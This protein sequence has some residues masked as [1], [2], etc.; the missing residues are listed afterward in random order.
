[1]SPHL[2]PET[3]VE[4][5]DGTLTQGAERLA[6][7]HLAGCTD[8][9]RR[10]GELAQFDG[11]VLGATA[12]D[13]ATDAAMFAVADRLL[14]R[15]APRRFGWL[16]ALLIAACLLAGVS[17]WLGLRSGPDTFAC[18][19]HRYVPD[20]RVRAGELER[21]HLDLDLGGPRW[22][23]V[24]QKGADGTV[25]R[26]FPD[27]NPVVASLGCD[28]PLRGAARVPASEITDWEFTAATAPRELLVAPLAAEP[29]AAALDSLQ[30]EYG[31]M[32]GSTPTPAMLG[33]SPEARVVP[34]PAR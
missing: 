22:L 18:G 31:G 4:Y 20:E 34:F 1:M 11:F 28:L 24:L 13:E 25:T 15:P 7:E 5:L 23:C 29:T 16:P 3:I 10:F 30:R 21:F 12:G 26:L 14:H 33:L 2:A 27:P 6:H 8:C 32:G 17:T 9:Q 19:I